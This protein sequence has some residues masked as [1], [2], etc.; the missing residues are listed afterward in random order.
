MDERTAA[1]LREVP[2]PA[3]WLPCSR[4]ECG[5]RVGSFLTALE[6]FPCPAALLD[7]H[8]VIRALNEPWRQFAAMASGTGAAGSVG[9]NY[10][11][12]WRDAGR[13]DIADGVQRVFGGAAKASE[14]SCRCDTVSGPRCLRLRVAPL[15]AGDHSGVLVTHEDVTGPTNAGEILALLA[16]H[17][18]EGTMVVDATGAVEWVN[19]AMRRLIG[20]QHEDLVGRN[21]GALVKG[22][23]PASRAL[24]TVREAVE[25]RRPVMARV[26]LLRGDRQVLTVEVR[27]E[28]IDDGCGEIGRY[29]ATMSDITELRH[30]EH[31]IATV[32]DDERRW[33][34]WDV[35]DGL[36]NE[37]T[38]ARLAVAQ[39]IASCDADNPVRESLLAAQGAIKRAAS[40]ARSIAHGVIS[41]AP[42]AELLPALQ[43]FAA[44]MSL[45]GVVSVSVSCHLASLPTGNRADLLY[46]ICQEAVANA[47][48]RSRARHVVISL[49]EHAKGLE[50]RIVDD[51]RGFNVKTRA[52]K[53]LRMMRMRAASL[54]GLLSVRSEPGSGSI[55]SCTL[56]N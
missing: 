17:S 27:V 7:E 46:G 37:V 33:L 55:V 19:D 1:G 10:L 15:D 47:I 38:A 21:V 2:T 20:L 28:P 29:F 9:A 43:R 3:Q 34:A 51:G 48:R 56:G 18:G 44:N 22:N 41:L 36:G 25:T 12:G 49:D 52:G 45:S 5:Q 23:A 40:M 8:G 4:L 24:G 54:G 30:L 35:H 31:M 16:M 50:L 39:A 42:D 11:Q 6:V 26:P 14:F 32:A 53:E 13:A